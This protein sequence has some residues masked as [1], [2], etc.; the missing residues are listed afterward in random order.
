MT[1]S[2][3][4]KGRIAGDRNAIL[5]SLK[6]VAPAPLSLLFLRRAI[7]SQPEWDIFNKDIS[8]LHKKGYIEFVRER[9]GQRMQDR[10]VELTAAGME[11]ADEMIEDQAL[12][13]EP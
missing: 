8:Y 1:R 3:E 6:R 5:D 2:F 9:E 13:P 12:N 10:W 7:P 4:E 11:A